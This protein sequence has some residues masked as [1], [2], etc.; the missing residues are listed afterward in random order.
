[1]LELDE[2]LCEVG[3]V[4]VVDDE[5]GGDGGGFGIGEPAFCQFFSYEVPDGLGA[6]L[7]ALCG[8][9]FVEAGEEA[10]LE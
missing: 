1:M 3:L 7:I 8:Y 10:V 2:F 6:V 5:D 9:H 4:M